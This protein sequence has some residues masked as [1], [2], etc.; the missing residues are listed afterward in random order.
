MEQGQDSRDMAMGFGDV[1]T[2][3]H[4]STGMWLGLKDVG[5]WG[6]GM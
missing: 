3:A 6:L 1:W 2:W 4:E 5:T